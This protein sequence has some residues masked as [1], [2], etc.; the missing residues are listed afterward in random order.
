MLDSG[1]PSNVLDKIQSAMNTIV[2]RH[3]ALRMTVCSSQGGNMASSMTLSVSPALLHGNLQLSWKLNDPSKLNICTFKQDALNSHSCDG[4][5]TSIGASQSVR[6]SLAVRKEIF[7]LFDMSKQLFRCT[8]FT[9]SKQEVVICLVFH[10]LITDGTSLF[11]LTNELLALLRDDNIC[12]EQSFHMAVASRDVP[13]DP[14]TLEIAQPPKIDPL[15]KKRSV[16]KWVALLSTAERCTSLGY[17]QNGRRTSISDTNIAEDVFLEL[18]HES[19]RSVSHLSRVYRVSPSVVIAT[20][21]SLALHHF[22]GEKDIIIGMVC[23]NRTGT[24]ANAVGYFAN[25]LPLRV[26]LS[27]QN[28]NDLQTLM[29]D[30]RKNWTMILAGGI[31]LVDLVPLI[32]CLQHGYNGRESCIHSSPLQVLFSYYD[33]GEGKSLPNKLTISGVEVDCKVDV[34]KPGHTHADLWMEANPNQSNRNGKQVLHWEYRVSVLTHSMVE[35]LHLLLCRYL[36]AAGDAM[37][38]GE[39]HI[40]PLQLGIQTVGLNL[41]QAD[42]NHFFEKK[43]LQDTSHLCYIQRFELKAQ[44]HPHLPAFRLD[45]G[46][47]YTYSEVQNMLTAIALFLIKT[48]QV[49][50]GD[51]IALLLPRDVNLYLF[52]LAVLKCGA[53]YVPVTGDTSLTDAEERLLKT[54]KVANVKLLLTLRSMWTSPPKEIDC[55]VYVDE[56]VANL[57]CHKSSNLSD[58]DLTMLASLEA[59]YSPQLLF[60]VLFTSGTTGEPKAVGI[61]NA[62]L[63][64]TFNNFLQLMTPEETKLTL[65]A[66]SI[67]FDSHI[68]DSFAPLLNGACLVV[69]E[70]PLELAD[71]CEK[72]CNFNDSGVSMSRKASSSYFSG[73][74]FAF[75]TPSTASVVDYPSSMLAIIIG[76]EVFTRACYNNTRHIPRVLNVYG[77]TE[78]SV[79]VTAIEVPRASLSSENLTNEDIDRIGWPLPEV[80]V[81]IMNESK[82]V[83]P[84]GRVG[85]L[86]IAGPIVSNTGYLNAVKGNRQSFIPN[87]SNPEETVYATGDLMYM[88]PNSMLQF[89]GRK[90]GQVKIRGMRI[91]LQEVTNA[92]SSHSDVQYAT[93]LVIDPATPSAKLVSFVMPKKVDVLSLLKHAR[94]L[95]PSH[96]VPSIII[97]DDE[98]IHYKLSKDYIHSRALKAI[99][100]EASQDS[101]NSSKKSVLL[102]TASVIAALFGKV[103]DVQE[104]PVNG[105][106]FAFGGHS[107]LCFQLLKEVNQEMKVGLSLT[108]IMQNPTPLGLANI[109]TELKVEK[110]SHQPSYITSRLQ[111]QYQTTGSNHDKKQLG[112]AN[113]L[114]STANGAANYFDYLEPVP[115]LPMSKDLEANLVQMLAGNKTTGILCPK[116]LQSV[117]NNLA[118]ETGFHI[119]PDSLIHYSSLEMLQGHLKLKTVLSFTSQPQKVVVTLQPPS[120][121]A[122]VPVFFI[123]S[124]VIGWSLSYAKL[125]KRIGTY[126]IAIQR[127]PEASTASFEEM[128]AY[129]LKQI[130]SVQPKGPYRLVGVCYGAYFVYEMMRQLSE[131]GEKVDLAVLINNSP[132]NENRPTVFNEQ[133]QPL[134]NTMAHPYYFYE[135]TLKL[136]LRE[137]NELK[138]QYNH[139]CVDVGKLASSL[140]EAYP[141]LPFSAKELAEAYVQFLKTLKPAWFGYNPRPIKQS[142]LA[143]RV[144]LIRNKE[145]TFFKSQDFG[146]LKLLSS[147]DLLKVIV[148]PRKL[149]L[150]NEEHTVEFISD[151]IRSNLIDLNS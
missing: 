113:D 65:A 128:T 135:T 28:A 90:D 93:S 81:M 13:P 15:S 20:M 54:L 43:E 46:S 92:L 70:S 50:L 80:R 94:C 4:H 87:P 66:T 72:S 2:S 111:V 62:N 41:S 29:K 14:P 102:N 109:L 142:A 126:S 114:I 22:T 76:G 96:M 24:T 26:N 27:A 149:G 48:F 139:V 30:V 122:D 38:K 82:H 85:E 18:S 133:G 116:E 36:E 49:E 121:G 55:A 71:T 51:R 31:D 131:M 117:S 59:T 67:N 110:E 11:I 98:P 144:I 100:K 134:P 64:P 52:V 99:K 57:Q 37:M 138:E 112:T 120:S 95:L 8:V 125:A 124:G 33:V 78:C 56:M 39:T 150:L 69:A 143:E 9:P 89:V 1:L 44:E 73:I 148:S 25:T 137:N 129:Y 107:L 127:T 136:R 47:V 145:H 104:Y 77:P 115:R 147:S 60:Y 105:N 34:P 141:W 53:A 3:D 91:H 40:N 21:Y 6:T 123:H 58:S 132:V 35:C 83:V 88:L 101:V 79:F 75:A 23:A 16:E 63:N 146:L 7:E 19:S 106:F 5:Q 17:D 103:L 12:N 108:H 61:T 151:V 74:T 130:Q 84:I 97:T 42:G 68:F 118:Q 10:H 32:P 140:L 86:H 45:N 119:P